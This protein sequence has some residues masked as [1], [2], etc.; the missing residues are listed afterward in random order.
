MFLATVRPIS[1]RSLQPKLRD[2]RNQKLSLSLS[3]YSRLKHVARLQG[4]MTNMP[5]SRI[6]PSPP[7]AHESKPPVAAP[8]LSSMLFRVCPRIILFCPGLDP[9]AGL[10]RHLP[11]LACVHQRRTSF[12]AT[13]ACEGFAWLARAMQEAKAN[14]GVQGSGYSVRWKGKPRTLL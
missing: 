11:R 4:C 1:E 6:S 8:T 5:N 12:R 3:R 10:A 7:H 2:P 13:S 9:W 14:E